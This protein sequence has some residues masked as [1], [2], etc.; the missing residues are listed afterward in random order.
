MAKPA[1]K[2]THRPALPKALSL[3]GQRIVV[4]GAAS[5]I[6]HAAAL[7]AA[8]LG[9]RL[10]LV[11]R[12]P[13]AALAAELQALGTKAD[14]IEGDLTDPAFL[15]RVVESGRVD[16]LAHC[17]GILYPSAKSRA[18]SRRDRFLEVM[19][20]NVRVPIELGEALIEPMAAQGGGRIVMIGS[21][22]G[23]TG[24]TTRSTPVDYAASKGALHVIVRWL[25][26]QAV[27]QGVLVNG[28][29]PGPI[30]TPMTTGAKFDAALL[31]RGRMGRPEEIAWMVTMLLTP[32]ASFVS[33]AVL[34]VNGG[35]YV[36]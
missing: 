15:K 28:V 16:G 20:I 18:R 1:R 32:A 27:G 29:A 6:G 21:V 5:G 14:S 24:G 36:G 2:E 12:A 30:E 11:D 35:G 7:A 4:T 9:A 22:A 33:G 19:D 26:R 17:A 10:L 23:R 8:E 34:D 13:L 3:A 25:S 31:P